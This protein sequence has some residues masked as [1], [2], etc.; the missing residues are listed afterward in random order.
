MKMTERRKTA[1]VT[2]A[3][4]GI[5]R[6]ICVRLSKA[7]FDIAFTFSSDE[8]GAEET[9]S[10]C[11]NEGAAV[12]V[13]K[14]DCSDPEACENTV[15]DLAEKTGGFIDVLVNNAGI[16]RD[17]LAVRMSDEDFDSVINANLKGSFYMM[18][19]VSKIM[20]RK[21]SGRIINISSIVGI[22]GN[23]GQINYAASKAA[24]IGMT[25]SLAKELASR[26]ITVNS[27]APGMIGT[28][29]TA[30]MTDE[31][32]E[33][34][35]RAI[36]FGEMGTPEDVAAAVAFFAGEESGYITGQ[37]LCVDGGLAV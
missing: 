24:V 13:Y 17:G 5:G 12:Y 11:E 7:G 8:K 37:V 20:I 32:K 15:K 16:T 14:A 31:A 1:L 18:R 6:A 10:A 23:A 4:R 35:L 34:L 28:A 19:A 22:S 25:K 27:V 29:M 21:R 3:S 30:A 36:P 26:K 9:R 33:S 2:G